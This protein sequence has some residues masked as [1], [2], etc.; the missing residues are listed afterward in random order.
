MHVRI[1]EPVLKEVVFESTL[2]TD[3][4]TEKPIEHLVMSL[5]HPLVIGTGEVSRTWFE[6][7]HLIQ[8]HL[9]LIDD[10]KLNAECDTPMMEMHFNLSGNSASV[11]N[12]G[13]YH[14]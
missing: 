4:V 3:F 11:I 14:F 9:Q 13:Q 2:P 1:T 5:D 10:V 8:G 12:D 7:V 6:G